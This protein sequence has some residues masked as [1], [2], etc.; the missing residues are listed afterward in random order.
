MLP[1]PSPMTP[2]SQPETH[3]QEEAEHPPPDRFLELQ[4]LP[5]LKRPPK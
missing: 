1:N 5:L 3:K 4:N 2:L